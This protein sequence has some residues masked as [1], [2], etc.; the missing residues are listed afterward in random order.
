MKSYSFIVFLLLFFSLKTYSQGTFVFFGSFNRDKTEEGIV[1]Y[2]LDTVSGLLS[3]V[4]GCNGISNPSFLTLSPGGNYLYA[5][6]DSKTPNA[7]GVAA[8]EFNPARKELSAINA[9]KSGGE[10]PVYLTVH[11]NGKWLV[12]ANY[13]ESSISVYPLAKNG[14]IE[15]M[16]QLF[17]FEDSSV[18]AGRQDQSHIHS[19]V[20]SPDYTTVLACDLGADKIRVFQFDEAR[21]EPMTEAEIPFRKTQLGAGPR[22]FVFH[23][24]GQFAYSINE[25]SGSISVFS[26]QNGELADLQQINTHGEE[27]T[28]GFESSDIH[29]SPD[30]KFLYAANRG[31]ENNLAVFSVAGDGK[32]TAVGY[33]STRGDHPRTF[34]IDPSGKFVIVTNVV[35]GNVA[36]FKRDTQTGLLTAVDQDIR[37]PNV[38]CVKIRQY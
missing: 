24:N 1:V 31:T 36:V 27:M 38:S 32:L 3:K 20:F 13:T 15:P 8:F 30:G 6:T 10:N 18:I 14:A 4:T 26:Y 11:Q 12:N 7:G 35:S 22:H 5:C 33:Q 16:A 2:E 23:P 29:L 28:V 25:L 9:Q 37:I 34:A 21:G 17:Q 19:V